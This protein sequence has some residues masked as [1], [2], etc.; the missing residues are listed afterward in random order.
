M[1]TDPEFYAIIAGVILFCMCVIGCCACCVVY[2]FAPENA[3]AIVHEATIDGQRILKD[4][5]VHN[6]RKD[7]QLYQETPEAKSRPG[8]V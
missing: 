5:G 2:R 6:T 1:S 3:V 8:R 4:D 7:F